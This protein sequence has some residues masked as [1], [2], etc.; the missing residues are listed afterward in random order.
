MKHGEKDAKILGRAYLVKK[1]Q[2]R[3]FP[4]RQALQALNDVIDAMKEGLRLS[5]DVEFPLG[6]LKRVRHRHRK[7]EGNFL[8]RKRTIYG[9][10]WTVKHEMDEAGDKRL[11][12]RPKLVV[13]PPKPWLKR[14]INYPASK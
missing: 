4:R 10:S 5:E 13:L 6:K 12:P 7:Q 9:R 8:G 1:L 14:K 11:N 3:G 2:E